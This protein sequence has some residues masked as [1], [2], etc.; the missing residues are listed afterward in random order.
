[1]STVCPSHDELTRLV[2]G[3]IT[4]NRTAALEAHLA[5]CPPCQREVGGLRQ[6][7][8]DLARPLPGVPSAEHHAAIMRRLDAAPAPRRATRPRVALW[9]GALGGVAAA[10]AAVFLLMVPREPAFQAR[11]T[12]DGGALRR[13]VG[14]TV[15]RAGE[16]LAP[17]EAGAVVSADTRLTVAYRNHLR[18]RAVYLMV[19]AID[20]KETVHWLFPAFTDAM[21]DPPAMALTHGPT[22]TVMPEAV[23]LE[24]PA[25]GPLR[26]VSLITPAPLRV[27]TVESLAPDRLTTS[28]LG[29]LAR[30]GDLREITV[31]VSPEKEP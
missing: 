20:A 21:T 14:V 27:S 19:F 23:A 24:R 2:D 30:D 9:A 17:L 28:A 29:A 10:A 12:A 3:E 5:A 22:D 6:V 25:A 15:Y 13:L 1:M 4:A 7:L 11:G 26:I 8:E 16:R 31:T 18:D